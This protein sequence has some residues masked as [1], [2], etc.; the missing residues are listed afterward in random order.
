[1]KSQK[2]ILSI[3]S[4]VYIVPTEEDKALNKVDL[5]EKYYL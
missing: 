3:K 1:M 5:M 2:V 4:G